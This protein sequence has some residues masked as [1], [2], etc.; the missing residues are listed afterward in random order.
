MCLVTASSERGAGTASPPVRP[1]GDHRVA[2][3]EDSMGTGWQV[4]AANEDGRRSPQVR[5]S[6]IALVALVGALATW[7][8]A[9]FASACDACG[10]FRGVQ[11]VARAIVAFSPMWLLL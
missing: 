5:A 6:Q 9:T 7:I 3:T 2:V 4:P 8:P 11:V 1:I 10:E